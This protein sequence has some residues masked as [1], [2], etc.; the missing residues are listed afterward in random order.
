M[1]SMTLKDDL[2]TEVTKIFRSSWTTRDGRV[3]P[4]PEALMSLARAL[5]EAP[6]A[7]PD[8]HVAAIKA[9]IPR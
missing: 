5:A 3:V 1:I 8:G 7:A 9:M 6:L 2:Q 4:A